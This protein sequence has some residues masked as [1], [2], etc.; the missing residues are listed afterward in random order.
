M[1]R[2]IRE[3][4]PQT[5]MMRYCYLMI[6]LLA[7]VLLM[8]ACEKG[9]HYPITPREFVF[10]WAY[11]DTSADQGYFQLLP[12]FT[13]GD[14][15]EMWTCGY[16]VNGS[17][18]CP[19]MAK[20][21]D[22]G[23]MSYVFAS[24]AY[25]S[26]AYDIKMQPVNNQVWATIKV[27][28]LFGGEGI[29]R[30]DPTL[31]PPRFIVVQPSPDPGMLD[32]Y[33]QTH[34]VM[35]TRNLDQ[36]AS[37]LWLFDGQNWTSQPFLLA[38]ISGN[39]IDISTYGPNYLTYAITDDGHVVRWANQILSFEDMN[40]VLYSIKITGTDEGWL[41]AED[42]LYHK[43]ADTSWT[44][45]SAFPGDKAFSVS[46]AGGKMWIAGEKGGVKKV[47]RLEGNDYNEE[48]TEGTGAGR[49]IMVPQ[50]TVPPY[51]GYILENL[52]LLKR[53]WEVQ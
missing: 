49:L 39:V 4:L 1:L 26:Y 45:E 51:H 12:P 17:F 32:F 30:F 21:T 47:W 33:D 27:E 44:K 9:S 5:C 3:I 19:L 15:G 34:G 10:N 35:M 52:R 7:I 2:L 48:S 31:T 20:Y 6:L 22:Q 42:G 23:W 8:P 16:Y 14:N 24:Q 38:P 29:Y 13:I 53:Q 11:Y 37:A 36:A 25:N 28:D 41:C 43:T 40:K 46:F 50:Q 18:N